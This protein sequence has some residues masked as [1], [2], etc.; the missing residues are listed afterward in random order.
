MYMYLCQKLKFSTQHI[1]T[2]YIYLSH[3]VWDSITIQYM[4]IYAYFEQNTFPQFR[5]WC[6]R[7]E[8]ENLMAQEWHFSTPSSFIQWSATT[9]PGWSVTVQLYT[10]PLSSPTNTV[11]WSLNTW[12]EENLNCLAL[13]KINIQYMYMYIIHV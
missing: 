3:Q 11:R 13:F 9:R 12:K 1:N 7:S 10:R 8:N 5:Q 4:C 6:L 2:Y